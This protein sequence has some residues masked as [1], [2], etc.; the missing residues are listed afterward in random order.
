M[1]MPGSIK[2]L[3]MKPETM[4]ECPVCYEA[5]TTG[6]FTTECG[7]KFHRTCMRRWM[8]KNDTCPMCRDPVFM[9]RH[10]CTATTLKG[11]QCSFRAF[12]EHMT[13]R[14]HL[15]PSLEL[16]ATLDDNNVDDVILMLGPLALALMIHDGSY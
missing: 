11:T 10:R 4:E 3:Y 12:G 1:Y 7:H 5:L 14:K 8:E 2:R 9:M 6:V 15:V 13:C 16:L